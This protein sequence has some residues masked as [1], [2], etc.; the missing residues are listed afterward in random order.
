MEAIPVY[1][2]RS[3]GVGLVRLVW[4]GVSNHVRDQMHDEPLDLSK[5]AALNALY[6]FGFALLF[7]VIN[8]FAPNA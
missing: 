8:A 2:T 6:I 3:N 1:S 7:F 4:R 5:G